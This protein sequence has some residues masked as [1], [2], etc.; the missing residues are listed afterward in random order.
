MGPILAQ[1]EPGR[2][3]QGQ[4]DAKLAIARAHKYASAVHVFLFEH[5]LIAKHF[6]KLWSAGEEAGTGG[7]EAARSPHFSAGS[8]KQDSAVCYE[9]GTH[10]RNA[11]RYLQVFRDRDRQ[12]I[13]GLN[14][15]ADCLVRP[16]VA[17]QWTP[18]A[19]FVGRSSR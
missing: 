7:P 16:C 5:Q 8:R 3:K 11:G 2:Q 10:R 19:C 17:L 12:D 14:E 15:I 9:S 18:L 6:C 4:R 13:G 1:S